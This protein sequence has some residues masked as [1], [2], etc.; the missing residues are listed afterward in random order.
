MSWRFLHVRREVFH[1]SFNWGTLFMRDAAAGWDELCYTYELPW[2]ADERGR[3]MNNVSRIELGTYEMQVRDDGPKG[4]RL[5]LLG[6]GH[7]AHIQIHRAHQSMYIE[8]CI[9]PVHFSWDTA[10][11]PQRGDQLIK[12]R[13]MEIMGKIKTRY[14]NLAT[15]NTG[16]PTVE[17]SA[18]LP[19]LLPARFQTTAPA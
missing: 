7:R 1:G 15:A 13:S 10:N 18:H 17:I 8:G 14:E 6:T 19:P 3:S 4:W 12:T 9:L 16:R 5:E 11:A 2:R